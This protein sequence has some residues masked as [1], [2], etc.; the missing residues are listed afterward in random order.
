MYTVWSCS[1]LRSSIHS[2]ISHL[3][4]IEISSLQSIMESVFKCFISMG[5]PETV[6]YPMYLTPFISLNCRYTTFR[7][8]FGK[9][10][11][12]YVFSVH[13]SI[14]N[15]WTLSNEKLSKYIFYRNYIEFKRINESGR[16]FLSEDCKYY[17]DLF[18]TISINYYLCSGL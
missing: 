17:T 12:S 9:L 15:Y 2:N 13:D 16:T 14:I 7:R 3:I 6:F 11:I 18:F 5:W 4:S 1:L 10:L 8:V